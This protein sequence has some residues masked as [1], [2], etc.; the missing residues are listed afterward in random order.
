MQRIASLTVAVFLA[1]AGLSAKAGLDLLRE[2]ESFPPWFV[3]AFVAGLAAL[4]AYAAFMSV[5]V[6][7]A[8]GTARPA[9]GAVSDV[10]WVLLPLSFV[11][12]SAVHQFYPFRPSVAAVYGGLDAMLRFNLALTGLGF[13]AAAALAVLYRAG[14]RE[15]ALLG[16]LAL[17][18][19]LLVPNDACANPFNE[20]WIATVG[21]SP[22][23]FVPNLYASL[24]AVAAL[25]GV[26]PRWNA[27]ALG[28]ACLGVALLG[29]GHMTRLIW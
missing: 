26:R 2:R 20:W 24:F 13:L 4:V 21:A 12:T 8:Q 19:L 23:M 29:L 7:R 14:R 17:D 11:C 3:P 27:A 5:R 25:L 1:A 9:A 18:A 10:V 6:W 16:L 15:A 28:A 22:L